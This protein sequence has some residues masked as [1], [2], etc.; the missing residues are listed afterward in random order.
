MVREAGFELRLRPLK[1]EVFGR[2]APRGATIQIKAGPERDLHV[3]S[4]KGVDVAL[5]TEMLVGAWDDVYDTAV[6]V[7]GDSDYVAAVRELIRH[8]KKVDV[9]SFLHSASR[10]LME[11]ASFVD[12]G[13][14]LS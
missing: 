1:V 13:K 12:L 9:V 11:S 3:F 14:L 4:E 8:G 10:E 7:S 2:R 6:L 5:V